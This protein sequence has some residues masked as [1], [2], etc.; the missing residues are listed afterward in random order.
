MFLFFSAA[1][2]LK[3]T[4]A[5]ARGR[6]NCQLRAC[7]TC[8]AFAWQIRVYTIF[9][10]ENRAGFCAELLL[11]ACNFLAFTY[12]YQKRNSNYDFVAETTCMLTFLNCCWRVFLFVTIVV[13]IPVE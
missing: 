7:G 2:T 1:H 11:F 13:G 12:F 5:A 9:H 10:M 4:T 3:A 6:R 8:G